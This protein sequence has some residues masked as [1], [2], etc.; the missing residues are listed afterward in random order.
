MNAS[1]RLRTVAAQFLR[2]AAL[3]AL[4]HN[5]FAALA[6]LR[7]TDGQDLA[8]ELELAEG[9]FV[10]APTNGAAVKLTLAELARGRFNLTNLADATVTNAGAG[11]GSLPAPWHAQDIGATGA[12]GR[13]AHTNGEFTLAGAGESSW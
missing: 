1:N 8:G 11:D 2:L 6:V 3:L 10:L 12:P 13:A 5:G 9:Q 4:V 7:T